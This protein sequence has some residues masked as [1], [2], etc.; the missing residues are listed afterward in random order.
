[1]K[2]VD[3][4]IESLEPLQQSIAAKLRDLLLE[5]IDGIEERF[6]FKIPFY[7]YFGMFCYINKIPGGVAI[8]FCRGK[9][10][11]MAFPQLEQENRAMIAL[12][13]LYAVADIKTKEVLQVILAAAEWNREA[14]LQKIP[15]VKRK[16]TKS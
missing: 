8:G 3:D 16:G 2:L 4:Y 11:V 6:S 15:M 10:L 13:R 9:D 5:H 12:I 14:K 1:M 7:Y